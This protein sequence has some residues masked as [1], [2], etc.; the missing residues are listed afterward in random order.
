MIG[1]R[2]LPQLNRAI[3][4]LSRSASATAQ[5]GTS[6]LPQKIES[7]IP[8]TTQQAPNYPST[9]SASQRPRPVGGEDPRFE[10]TVME[11]QPNPLSAMALIAEEPVRLVHGRKAVCDGG[12]SKPDSSSEPLPF[13]LTFSN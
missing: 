11:L 3:R 12:P 6:S 2:V 8:T 5:S 13:Q 4:T 9:W 7:S 1:R 10:Q